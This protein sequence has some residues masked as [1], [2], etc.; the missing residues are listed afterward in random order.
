M[1]RKDYILIAATI[2][3]TLATD[4][5]FGIDWPKRER[6]AVGVVAH[7]LAHRLRQENP[8]FDFARFIEA[9][10]LTA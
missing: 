5:E 8:Q 9:C 7:R 1:T 6:A 10:G 3:E 4:P 2:R